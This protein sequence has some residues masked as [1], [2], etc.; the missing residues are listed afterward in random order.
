MN[1]VKNILLAGR[2]KEEV[3]EWLEGKRMGFEFRLREYK[4]VTVGDIGWADVYIA[5]YPPKGVSLAGVKWVHALGAGVDFFIFRQDWPKETLLTRTKGDFGNRIG[6]YCV[7]RALAV[8][9]NLVELWEA[10]WRHEWYRK[11]AGLLRGS[12]VAIVGT[13]E[14]GRG[15]A[16]KFKALGCPVEGIS[17]SG[18]AVKPFDRVFGRDEIAEPL[19]KAE[20]IVLAVPLTEE[21]YMMFNESLLENCRGAYLINIARGEV[22]DED[23]LVEALDS[24]RL[25]GAALDVFVEEP[26]PAESPLWEMPNVLISPHIAAITSAEEAGE[27]FLACLAELQKGQRPKLAVDS[28]KGY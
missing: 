7:A 11:E 18:K 26:L 1:E 5:F 13:G 24:G 28:E 22:V 15:I 21:S 14:V 17:I 23:A 3:A 8:T 20:W 12:Q 6:E 16:A 19:K 10:Q 4:E 2:L 27:S 25:W 9:Q